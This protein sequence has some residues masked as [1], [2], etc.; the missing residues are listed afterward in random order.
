MS[1][2]GKL[3]K[4][5]FDNYE[6][7]KPQHAFLLPKELPLPQRKL[8]WSS[9]CFLI[10]KINA[11]IEKILY[12]KIIDERMIKVEQ[13][14]IA[15][16]FITLELLGI[17]VHQKEDGTVFVVRK[18]CWE[19]LFPTAWEDKLDELNE[20]INH[21]NCLEEGEEKERAKR[22]MKASIRELEKLGASLVELDP[23]ESNNVYYV[24]DETA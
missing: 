6:D 17:P 23:T 7:K 13:F 1:R 18:E 14:Y 9:V 19:I 16:M 21:M 15:R 4:M 24:F 10:D 5:K 2:Q 12:S 22:W 3:E 8:A 11:H 20:H